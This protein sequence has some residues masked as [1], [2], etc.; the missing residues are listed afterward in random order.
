MEG[1]HI[2]SVNGDVDP[3]SSLSMTK[4]GKSNSTDLPTYWSTGASHHFWTHQVKDND[5]EE[6]TKTRKMIYD[7]VINLLHNSNTADTDNLIVSQ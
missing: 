1:S 2:L 5:G 3:W 6:I 7:W 4:G